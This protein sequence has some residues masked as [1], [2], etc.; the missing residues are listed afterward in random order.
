MVNFQLNHR[1]SG[2]IIK[3]T[4]ISDRE[5]GGLISNFFIPFN[6]IHL[7]FYQIDN[8]LFLFTGNLGTFS[9]GFVSAISIRLSKSF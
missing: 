5:Y 7:I 4:V 6:F 9:V 1:K 2:H 8:M 3:R